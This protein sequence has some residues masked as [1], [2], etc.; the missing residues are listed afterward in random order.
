MSGAFTGCYREHQIEACCRRGM[1]SLNQLLRSRRVRYAAGVAVAEYLRLVRK[2]SKLVLEPPDFYEYIAAEVP[3]IVAMWH[4]QHLMMPFLRRPPFKAK[5][6][7]SAHPD[8]EINAVAAERLGVKAIRGSGDH[9]GRFNRKGGVRGFMRMRQALAEGYS[10]ALTSDLPKVARVAGAGT[11]L[12]ARYSGRPVYPV[13]VATSRRIELRNWDRTAINLPFS[14]FA[15]IIG[16][17]I[18]V[19]ADADE[20]AIGHARQAIEDE[21]NAVT[22]RAYAVVDEGRRKSLAGVPFGSQPTSRLNQRD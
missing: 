12:L 6:L 11:V 18:R 4:G 10:V 17:P 13:A 8:G 2:T 1:L 21:L 7:I 14:R 19:A 20:I 3:I 22:T 9:L 15:I 16:K 5:V